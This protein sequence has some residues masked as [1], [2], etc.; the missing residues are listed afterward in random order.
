MTL[1]SCT[2]HQFQLHL[3][4][5]ILI[6]LISLRTKSSKKRIG[7]L[8]V[9]TFDSIWSPVEVDFPISTNNIEKMFY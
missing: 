7:T 3:C 9:L 1:Q 2:S 5:A 8:F 6:V 4:Q